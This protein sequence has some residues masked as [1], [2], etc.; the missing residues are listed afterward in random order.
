MALYGVYQNGLRIDT[1]YR[2][3]STDESSKV[4]QQLIKKEHRSS[5]IVVRMLKSAR[6]EVHS[7]KKLKAKAVMKKVQPKK[8]STRHFSISIG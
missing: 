5:R 2:K 3:G 8:K 4:K 6:S 7:S 1:V